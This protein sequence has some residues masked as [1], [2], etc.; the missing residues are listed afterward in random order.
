MDVREMARLGGLARRKAMT[1]EE[2]SKAAQKAVRARFR[3]MTKAERK[4]VARK[5][6]Q[7]RWAAQKKKDAK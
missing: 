6:A 4:A 1:P 7:A 5:A 2:R 3:K